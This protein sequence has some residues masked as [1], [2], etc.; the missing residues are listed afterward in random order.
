VAYRLGLPASSRIHSV[1]HVS[2]LK[3]AKGFKGP[4]HFPL[5]DDIPEL[6]V[7]LQIIQSRGLTKGNRLVQQV[8][9]SWSGLPSEL[10][11]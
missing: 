3:L 8:L 11:T 6:S 10:T 9:V 4:A 5:P 2:Q 7:P 1:V